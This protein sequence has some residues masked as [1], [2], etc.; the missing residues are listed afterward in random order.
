MCSSGI[1]NSFAVR[2]KKLIAANQSLANIESCDTLLSQ[3]L[4]LAQGVTGAEAS[5]V[6][7]YDPKR[8][9]L[10]FSLAKN[11]VLGDRAGETLKN[12]IQVKMG[13]G[14]AGWVGQNHKSIIVEDAQKDA[15]L[16][17]KA[18]EST[19]FVTRTLLC[20]PILYGKDLLGV[21]QV[22]NS[23]WKPCFDIED[24]EILESFANL[25]AVAIIRTRLLDARLKQ[26]RMQVEFEAASR[27]Q[28]LFW[29]VIPESHNDSHIWAVSIPADLVGG[30]L[31][32]LIP[33]P[34]D[35]LLFY[36]ADVCGK[37]LPAALIMTSLWSTIRGYAQ[38]NGEV[39]KLLAGVN[40]AMCDLLDREGFFA[41]IILGRYWPQYS[42][43]WNLLS[44]DICLLWWLTTMAVATVSR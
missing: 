39:H 21:I 14:I 11:E 36:V 12:N 18:D 24:Q 35:S 34:D 33:M 23:K 15:R 29:P 40:D 31:Y 42:G 6:L 44:G 7:L 4:D 28:S 17:K 22:I 13:E 20:V 38:Q 16:L 27:I 10:K 2:L 19:G 26:Q 43:K 9:V 3:L 41:T 37:G 1:E 8:E 5:S 32:D 30:D 25:A